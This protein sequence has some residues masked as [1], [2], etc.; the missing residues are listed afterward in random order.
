MLDPSSA[1]PDE[2]RELGIGDIG[3]GLARLPLRI[4]GLDALL[5]GH[6]GEVAVVEHHHDEARIGPSAPV[7][8]DRDELGQAVHLHGA[9]AHKRNGG[10]VGKGELRRDPVGHRAAHGGERPRH[11]PHH[12]AAEAQVA[13][14]PHRGGAAVGADDGALGQA[15]RQLVGDPLRIDGIRFG[16]GHAARF[17]PG[18]GDVRLDR[19]APAPVGRRVEERQQGLEQRK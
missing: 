17:L 5:P 10:A 4:A 14:P 1:E 13:R 11:R 16:H 19:L 9:V 3:Q 8:R 18:G 2:A 7:L 15:L 6:V 12:A